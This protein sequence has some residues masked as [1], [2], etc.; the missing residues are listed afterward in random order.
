MRHRR[1]DLRKGREDLRKGRAQ[2]RRRLTTLKDE[3]AKLKRASSV[4]TRQAHCTA[5]GTR[6]SSGKRPGGKA[7]CVAS[8]GA[9]TSAASMHDQPYVA[10]CRPCPGRQ[11]L[12]VTIADAVIKVVATSSVA[13]FIHA[14]R[15]MLC[16][17]ATGPQPGRIMSNLATL[18]ACE[19]VSVSADMCRLGVCSSVTLLSPFSCF[20]CRI[21]GPT[22]HVVI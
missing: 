11:A 8:F 19:D 12:C 21:L 14:N 7:L 22:R 4:S 9:C 18:Y 20:P 1:E 16:G 6:R 17:L 15:L 13:D 3:E 5:P 2:T 10:W